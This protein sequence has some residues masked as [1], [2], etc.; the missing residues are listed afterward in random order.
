MKILSL[1]PGFYNFGWVLVCGSV[2][3]VLLLS[4][5][6]KKLCLKTPNLKFLIR[7]YNNLIPNKEV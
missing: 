1:D 4:R 3:R 5:S 2:P 7:K 6:A